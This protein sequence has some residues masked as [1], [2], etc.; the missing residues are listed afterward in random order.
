MRPLSPNSGGTG[1][2]VLPKLPQ[3]WGPSYPPED[4]PVQRKATV[5]AVGS[6]GLH[7][8]QGIDFVVARPDIQ[9]TV[10]AESRRR[11]DT[12]TRAKFPAFLAGGSVQRIDFG[13]VRADVDGAIRADCRGRVDGAPSKEFPS[14]AA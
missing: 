13:I 4:L 5:Y 11:V 14:L 8:A 3:T 2:C 6:A 9:N 10:G 7:S 12:V 1:R